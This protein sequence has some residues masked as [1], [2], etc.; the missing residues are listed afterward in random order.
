MLGPGGFTGSESD[1]CVYLL[2]LQGP[3]EAG[4]FMKTN[5]F[6]TFMDVKNK[7]MMLLSQR[8]FVVF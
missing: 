4:S 5:T 3:G 7:S 6:Y 2:S 8:I 1:N